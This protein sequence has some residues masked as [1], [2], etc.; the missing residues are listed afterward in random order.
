MSASTSFDSDEHKRVSRIRNIIWIILATIVI[1]WFASAIVRGANLSLYFSLMMWVTMAS[2]FNII[3]GFTGYVPFGFV[4]FYGIGSYTT[5]ILMKHAELSAIIAI[6][7]AAIAGI[8]LGLLFAPTLSLRGIYFA[9]VSL[10]LAIICQRTVSL[11][12]ESIT[13]G[14][15][16]INLG[17]RTLREAAFILMILNMCLILAA[18][19]WLSRSRLGMALRAIR[20]DPGAA[21]AMGVNVQHSRLYAWIF[22]TVFP[23]LCGGIQTLFTGAIDSATAFDVFVTAKSIIYAMAGGLGSVTGPVIGAVVLVWVDELIWRQWPVLSTFL[24]GLIISLLILFMP[25]GIIGTLI[26]FFPKSRRYI[27]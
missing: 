7:A 25:R 9:I 18:A 5:G 16:G 13:G 10:S 2:A 4:A 11:M 6:P 24:L 17:E 14:S 21:D 19:T 3:A 27:V 15:L 22:A 26:R 20:D 8:L 12:P 1:I 23:A